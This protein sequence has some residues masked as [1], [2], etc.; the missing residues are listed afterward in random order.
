MIK[1]VFKNLI[2]LA[3][4]F[5]CKNSIVAQPTF[6]Y[7]NLN[8]QLGVQIEPSKSVYSVYPENYVF[9]KEYGRIEDSE[10]KTPE[11]T[12]ISAFSSCSAKAIAFV[13]V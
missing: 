12:L 2:L 11:E 3:V 6:Y 7:S 9:S 1:G 8:T 4:L 5:I 10:R 13:G